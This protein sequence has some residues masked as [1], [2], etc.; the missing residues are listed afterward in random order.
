MQGCT[1]G[2]TPMKVFGATA[3]GVVSTLG[4]AAMTPPPQTFA[5]L[6]AT[7]AEQALPLGAMATAVSAATNLITTDTVTAFAAQAS[8]LASSL[9]ALDAALVATKS[10]SATIPDRTGTGTLQITVANDLVDGVL[11]SQAQGVL[12]AL[13]L[14]RPAS[15][16]PH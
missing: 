2:S 11:L 14:N 4:E 10:Y 1:D 12:A 3:V 9:A 13:G 15:A 16:T 6:A 7:L 5:G 8:T